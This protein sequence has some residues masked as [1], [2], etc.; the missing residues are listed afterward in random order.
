M[1]Y[2]RLDNRC[3]SSS[4]VKQF[5]LDGCMLDYNTRADKVCLDTM[6]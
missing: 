2:T 3:N 1:Q 6:Q 4:Q 5:F